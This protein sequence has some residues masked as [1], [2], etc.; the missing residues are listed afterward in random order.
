MKLPKGIAGGLVGIAV[1]FLAIGI[2][3]G[4]FMRELPPG[5]REVALVILGTVMGWAGL[6]VSFH[7]GSSH[8]S[9]TKDDALASAIAGPVAADAPAA[10]QAVAD[11]AVAEADAIKAAEPVTPR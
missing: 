7:Y 2:V 5:N 4:L 1:M 8:G 11:A 6:V 9:R 3:V 10:A